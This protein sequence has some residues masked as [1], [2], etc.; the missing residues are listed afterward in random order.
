MRVLLTGAGGFIGLH[1]AYALRAA[2]HDVVCA[3]RRPVRGFDSVPCDMARDVEPAA[4]R[5]RL[6]GVDAVVNCAGILRQR[7]GESFDAVHHDAPLALA[8]A[9]VDAGVRRF[10]QISALGDPRDAAFVASKHRFDAALAQLDLEHVVLRPSVVYATH[11]SYGGTS[12]LRALAA[13]PFVM[14]I[15]AGGAQT[16]Q[17]LAVEDLAAA[18]LA[19]LTR[20][21]PARQ[22]I[23]LGGPEALRLAE[24]LRAWRAWLGLSPAREWRAP[25]S[26]VRVAARLGQML[27]AGPTGTT[28]QRMLERGNVVASGGEARAQALLGIAPRTLAQALAAAPAQVQDRWHARLHFLAPVLRLALALLFVGSGVAGFLAPVDALAAMLGHTGIP[29]RGLVVLA[30]L[31]SAVDLALGVLLLMRVRPRAVLAAMLAVTAVYTL[32]LGIAAPRSWLEPLGGLI[33][34]LVL[35]PATAVAWALA[36]A[37]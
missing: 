28:M 8:R 16:L 10:V 11:G 19:A 2:G 18:V 26:L 30:A 15:P 23:E 5:S 32:F 25:R 31:G 4:W 20:A 21:E 37:R 3:V 24:Y 13:L 6:T 22:T 33:K 29:T 34:N 1:L 12:T 36:D 27:G 7:R 17:P 35:L 14:P 9:C